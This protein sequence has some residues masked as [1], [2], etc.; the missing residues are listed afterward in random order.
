MAK[1]TLTRMIIVAAPSGAGKSSF[2]ERICR[3]EPRLE[4]TVTFTTREMRRGESQGQP[5]HFVS[6]EKFEQLIEQNYF[7]EWA[8]VHTSMYGT[9]L[10]QIENAF[11]VGKCIIMDV[12]VQGARTFKAKYSD[13]KSL[14]ILPPTI[15]ELRRRLLKRDGAGAKDIDVRLKNAEKELLHADEFDFQIVNDEFEASYLHFKKIVEDLLG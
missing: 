5:Y 13:A 12:D 9:P 10:E 2:V 8:R 14:F 11:K 1:P 7:V 3:E 15:E 4:D 6:T